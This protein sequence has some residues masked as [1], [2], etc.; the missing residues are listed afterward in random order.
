MAT[1]WSVLGVNHIEQEPGKRIRRDEGGIGGGGNRHGPHGARVPGVLPR[2][3]N[4][5]SAITP[6]L[7]LSS[8]GLGLKKWVMTCLSW[9]V[10]NVACGVK[11]IQAKPEALGHIDVAGLGHGTQM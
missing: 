2:G 6:A 11:S 5:P 3:A 8:N 4:V 10:N 1:G 7:V 9:S